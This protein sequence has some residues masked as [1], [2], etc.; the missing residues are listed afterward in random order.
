MSIMV[1]VCVCV[2]VCVSQLTCLSVVN[3]CVCANVWCGG[4]RTTPFYV[5]LKFVFG[6]DEKKKIR[7]IFRMYKRLKLYTAC[8]ALFQSQN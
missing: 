5:D 4:G 7:T 6:A 8:L 3:M 1:C 2:C